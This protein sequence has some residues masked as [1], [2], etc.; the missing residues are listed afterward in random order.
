MDETSK[1][2]ICNKEVDASLTCI[3]HCTVCSKNICND[4]MKNNNNNVCHT[5]CHTKCTECGNEITCNKNKLCKDCD[6]HPFDMDIDNNAK[7]MT[8]E[9]AF[10]S[11]LSRNF[12]EYA[13]P[14]E[15][16]PSKINNKINKHKNK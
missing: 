3:N 5:M 2:T 6:R 11:I 1:C 14:E 16:K 13:K 7:S 8:L 12:E 9:D 4:C 10:D 15:K